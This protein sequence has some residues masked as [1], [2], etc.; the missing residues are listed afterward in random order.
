MKA[1]GR[2]WRRAEVWERER[3]DLWRLDRAC[4]SSGLGGSPSVRLWGRIWFREFLVGMRWWWVVV[5]A[6]GGGGFP[7]GFAVGGRGGR[8]RGFVSGG[9][10]VRTTCHSPEK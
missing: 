6:G 7:T 8:G 9:F 3:R 4:R 2:W 1:V 10:G 5:V